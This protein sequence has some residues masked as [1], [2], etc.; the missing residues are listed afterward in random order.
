MIERRK[1]GSVYV[2]SPAQELRNWMGGYTQK[3]IVSIVSLFGF[4][5][6]FQFMVV[7]IINFLKKEIS[8]DETQLSE[9]IWLP[10]MV[11]CMVGI[12]I[13]IFKDKPTER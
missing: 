8:G 10:I 3:I 2:K 6:L 5:F 7:G 1:L 4:Y 9:N 12:L 11:F 13:Y